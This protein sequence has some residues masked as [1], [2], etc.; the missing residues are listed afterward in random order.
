MPK[1]WMYAFNSHTGKALFLKSPWDIFSDFYENM[2]P[3]GDEL[4]VTN[5]RLNE[6]WQ[7]GFDDVERRPYIT[8]RY[9]DQI[10]EMHPDDAKV[11]GIESGDTVTVWSH[12]VPIWKDSN[13][14]VTS[15]ENLFKNLS[16]AGHIKEVSGSYS[17]VAVVTP[18]IKKGV[19]WSNFL[20][21]AQPVNSVS[22]SV[23]DPIS[24]QY[25]YKVGVGRV[26]KIGESP[27]KK[28]MRSMSFARQNIV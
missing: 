21:P 9:P 3:R 13:Q 20:S 2:R 16:K 5:G 18:G 24:Q 25:R 8:Q 10:V 12:R 26:K 7:S 28:D 17:G 27:Y 15:G 6:V 19:V 23:T 1:K 11:R 4:W 14:S 22:S